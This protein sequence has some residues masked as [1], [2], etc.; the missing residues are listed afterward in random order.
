[1]RLRKCCTPLTGY[2]HGETTSKTMA[3]SR[4]ATTVWGESKAVAGMAGGRGLGKMA[5]DAGPGQGPPRTAGVK[6]EHRAHRE[7]PSSPGSSPGSFALSPRRPPTPLS[8]PLLPPA[9]F[10]LA[11][12]LPPAQ[13]LPTQAPLVS[14]RP[15]PSTTMS[16]FLSLSILQLLSV[17]SFLTSVLAVLCVGSGSLHR[18]AHRVEPVVDAPPPDAMSSLT[19][20]KQPLWTWSGL[21]V[22]FSIDTLIGEDEPQEPQGYVGGTE[23][24][25]M[26]W[27]VS[28]SPRIGASSSP[29]LSLLGLDSLEGHRPSPSHYAH[30]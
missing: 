24:T 19:S 13:L 21:P 12:E 8:P 14:P 28:R 5:T 9:A 15:R 27:Q 11:A 3:T 25:R 23:L 26:D 10:A 4:T 1:M 18:L 17:F 20:G 29:S 6:R 22:S 16:D 30:V 2:H 7:W